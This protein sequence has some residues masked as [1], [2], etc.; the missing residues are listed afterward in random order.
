MDEIRYLLRIA[1]R[2]IHERW[3]QPSSR[4]QTITLT[5][6]FLVGVLLGLLSRR[7]LPP[8]VRD[9]LWM[10]G[11]AVLGALAVWFGVRQGRLLGHFYRWAK[12][13]RHQEEN[14]FTLS[15]EAEL[16]PLRDEFVK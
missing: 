7:W 4:R 16:E 2:A 5:L 13:L 15:Y 12:R 3:L 8:A 9:A 1:G 14:D 10:L 6:A 11:L